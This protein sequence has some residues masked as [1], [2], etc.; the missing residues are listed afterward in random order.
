MFDFLYHLHQDWSIFCIFMES[1]WSVGTYILTP[2]A[3]VQIHWKLLEIWNF[4]CGF[5]LKFSAFKP[6]KLRKF[7]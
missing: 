7:E 5:L 6:A 3:C 1:V 4:W 2:P